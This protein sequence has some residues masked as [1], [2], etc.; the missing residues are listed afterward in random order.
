MKYVSAVLIGIL[1]AV[2]CYYTA[3][4]P[5]PLEQW[6]TQA[7]LEKVTVRPGQVVT[8]LVRERV[9]EDIRARGDV[10]AAIAI[11]GERQSKKLGNVGV[12]EEILLPIPYDTWRPY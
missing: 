6:A 5:T 12:W 9:P 3:A 11:I 1:V 4:I 2:M 10:T 7:R 8:D